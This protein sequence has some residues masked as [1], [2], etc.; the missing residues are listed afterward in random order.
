MACLKQ[1]L[2][3]EELDSFGSILEGVVT[4][5]FFQEIHSRLVCL[6]FKKKT[7]FRSHQILKTETPQQLSSHRRWKKQEEMT[8]L[9]FF[10]REVTTVHGVPESSPRVANP[11]GAKSLIQNSLVVSLEKEVQKSHAIKEPFLKRREKEKGLQK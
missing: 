2:V 7:R 6:C 9:M 4:Q 10:G 11:L 8:K 3:D 1:V 5:K